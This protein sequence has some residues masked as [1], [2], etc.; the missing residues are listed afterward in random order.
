VFF[1]S[2]ADPRARSPTKRGGVFGPAQQMASCLASSRIAARINPGP[3]PRPEF[4][5]HQF[6]RG[7]GTLYSLSREGAANAGPLVTALT[8]A[9]V[10]AA[11]DYAT[12]CP[13]AGSRCR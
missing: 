2:A 10:K 6:V 7:A 4:N 5:P 12:T 3:V 1:D 8:A 11:E 9:V 13:A